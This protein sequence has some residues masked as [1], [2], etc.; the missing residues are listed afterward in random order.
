MTKSLCN[1]APHESITQCRGQ[2]T[3]SKSGWRNRT[4]SKAFASSFE[5]CGPV[6]FYLKI[7]VTRR[8]R[9]R[10]LKI[11]SGI[12]R[13]SLRGFRTNGSNIDRT[14]TDE[15]YLQCID[16]RGVE[17]NEDVSPNLT[18]CP[19][20]GVRVTPACSREN[21]TLEIVFFLVRTTKTE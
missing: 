16:D 5:I 8:S 18:H 4:V 9:I 3:C 7:A 20:P 13:A 10:G 11:S 19:W 1:S 17:I 12:L 15:K 14:R 21:S 2:S 6:S